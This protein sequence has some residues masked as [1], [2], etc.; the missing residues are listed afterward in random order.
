VH[1]WIVSSAIEVLG[2]RH[3]LRVPDESETGVG[4]VI[5]DW[6]SNKLF[7]GK[8]T[9]S[10]MDRR[11]AGGATIEIVSPP[12]ARGTTLLAAVS[13]HGRVDFKPQAREAKTTDTL[14]GLVNRG[15]SEDRPT[16]QG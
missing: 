12:L 11:L 7:D 3:V 2:R 13:G 8:V 15:E 9:S 10:E 4:A 16:Q 6:W 14:I 5:P 1:S